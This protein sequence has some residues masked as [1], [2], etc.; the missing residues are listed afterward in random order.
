LKNPPGFGLSEFTDL[1]M[2][3]LRDD[4]GLEPLTISAI[5]PPLPSEVIMIG[6]GRVRDGDP[7]YWSVDTDVEP[8]EWHELPTPT[9]SQY[10]GFE[11]GDGEK[12]WG[13]NWID[14]ISVLTDDGADR[15][16]AIALRARFQP[17]QT[18]FEARAAAGDSG[19]A[20]FYKQGNSWVLAGIIQSISAIGPQPPANLALVGDISN[21]ADLT[22]YR[23]QILDVMA[24]AVDPIHAPWQ[25]PQN[26]WN[27]NKD[28]VVSAADVLA[29]INEINAPAYSDAMTREL[30]DL[31]IGVAP[32]YYFDVNGDE[33]VTPTDVLAVINVLNAASENMSLS[34]TPEHPLPVGR[35]VP[36]PSAFALV[37]IGCLCLVAA[38][39]RVRLPRW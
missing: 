36:E 5:R 2:F 13:T 34:R 16:D 21:F 25:N 20:V 27:V 12:R 28:S 38:G 11:L 33:R 22:A 8:P 39:G 31:P 15:G 10:V 7:T 17:N 30:P 19:G 18:A 24:S 14:E 37:V 26:A 3:R 23:S 4:P 35:P 9:G 29:V 32:P 6:Y 1:Q